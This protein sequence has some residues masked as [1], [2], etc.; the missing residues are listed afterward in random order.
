[1]LGI[2]GLAFQAIEFFHLHFV[3]HLTFTS[4]P[5]CVNPDYGAS[6]Y[7][8]TETHGAVCHG[9]RARPSVHDLA[10]TNIRA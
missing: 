7:V 4:V 6:F 5:G 10:Y 9:R 8:Q 3:D 2:T 1:L